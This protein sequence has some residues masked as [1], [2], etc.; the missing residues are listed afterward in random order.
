MARSLGAEPPYSAGSSRW[1]RPERPKTQAYTSTTWSDADLELLQIQRG[2]PQGQAR[3]EAYTLLIAINTWKKVL[4][5][6]QGRLAIRGDALGVLQGVVKMR[7]RDPILNDI[8]S[9]IAL[10]LA[11]QGGD[12]RAAHVWSE[13]NEIC[14]QPS[15]LKPSATDRVKGP[16]RS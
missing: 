10:I 6:A 13:E 7:A 12:L 14:D 8:T 4:V 15:R 3:V 16:G 5:E 1:N 9:E 2:N 11:L